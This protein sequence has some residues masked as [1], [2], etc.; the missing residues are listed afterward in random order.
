MLEHNVIQLLNS[1]NLLQIE[2]RCSILTISS[3]KVRYTEQENRKKSEKQIR[4][5]FR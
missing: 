4:L 3:F 2:E 1:E 5:N